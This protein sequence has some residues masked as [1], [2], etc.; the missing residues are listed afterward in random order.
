VL[1]VLAVADVELVLL[2]RKL[3]LVH[4]LRP[5]RCWGLGTQQK[6]AQRAVAITAAIRPLLWTTQAMQFGRYHIVRRAHCD[7]Q[8]AN[9]V[10][11]MPCVERAQ[12][13]RVHERLIRYVRLIVLHHLST[14]RASF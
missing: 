5:P 7:V 8:Q 3:A 1:P 9:H 12:R 6:V 4:I 13:H 14:S 11:P 2:W 10:G